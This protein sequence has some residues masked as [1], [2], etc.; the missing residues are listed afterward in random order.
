M[1]NT[2]HIHFR[3]VVLTVGMHRGGTSSTAGLI[4]ILGASAP[5]TLMPGD[6]NNAHGY[7]E[8]IPLYELH[9]EILASAGSAWDDWR[10][11]PQPFDGPLGRSYFKHK[12]QDI[13]NQEFGSAS[14][15]VLKDPRI[16][17]FLPL[18]LEIFEEMRIRPV[19][20]LPIRSPLEVARSLQKRDTFSITKGIL[21]WLRHMLDAEFATR[22]LPRSFFA[23][24]DLLSDWSTVAKRVAERCQIDWPQSPLELTEK[25]LEFL[26]TD[27]RH[28]EI[29]DDDL[30]AHPDAHSWA[31][32]TYK[33]LLALSSEHASSETRVTLDDLRRKLNDAV[34]LFNPILTESEYTLQ[35]AF[36]SVKSENEELRKQARYAEHRLNEMRLSSS[37]HL[38]ALAKVTMERDTAIK[39]QE[40]ARIEIEALRKMHVQ[41]R[42]NEDQCRVIDAIAERAYRTSVAGMTFAFCGRQKIHHIAQKLS[43]AH[44]FDRE[45]YL[46]NYTEVIKS[47]YDP[48]EHYIRLGFCRGYF[49]H[50]LFDTRYYFMTNNDVLS[51][52]LNPLFHYITH[53]WKE[54][55]NPN[56]YF[57]SA[58]YLKASPELIQANLSPLEH[59]DTIGS[60]EKRNPGPL[61][62][63]QFYLE[64]YP[65]ARRSD[66]NALAHYIHIG[67]D[68]GYL[69][70]P[71]RDRPDE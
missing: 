67:Q 12:A 21:L 41:H 10:P 16:C 9:E 1:Q 52:G 63:T 60:S 32:Q 68:K 23:W 3:T 35:K 64:T 29:A 71:S 45:F 30:G 48:I 7:F 58:F 46:R 36:A 28:H 50:P 4:Q 47:G 62:D 18:W 27:L 57:D 20:V 44:L 11:F 61:F 70:A 69:P 26:I 22:G 13:F 14:L 49:P 51:S 55:R 53:G 42:A 66:M 25:I 39:T 19:A 38:V 17:R 40:N 34:D 24:S 65:D 37:R 6:G 56:A 8:S 2:D 54:G 33:C 5:K 59:Y 43:E 31:Q 15:M